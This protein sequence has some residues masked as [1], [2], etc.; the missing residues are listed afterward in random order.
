MISNIMNQVRSPKGPRIGPWGPYTIMLMVFGPEIPII[1]VLG[2]L[3]KC[4]RNWPP[5]K[6]PV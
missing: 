3:G 2:F 5:K 4:V 6:E 1:R